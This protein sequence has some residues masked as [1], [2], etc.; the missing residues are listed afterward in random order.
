MVLKVEL[1]LV[2]LTTLH[3]GLII[4]SD[5]K[6]IF[7]AGLDIKELY[8]NKTEEEMKSMIDFWHYL[9]DSWLNLYRLNIPM[10]A[11]VNGAAIAGGCLIACCADTRLM[12]NN[13]KAWEY[14]W[15]IAS[16]YPFFQQVSIF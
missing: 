1:T 12:I 10:V 7:C 16:N 6:N 15:L 9:Q 13:P 8:D 14:D 2:S 11:A 3:K 5:V 4:R